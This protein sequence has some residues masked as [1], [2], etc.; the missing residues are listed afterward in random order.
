VIE[1]RH[2][3]KIFGTEATTVRA[4]DD[5]SFVLPQG[6][7]WSIMGPSGAGKSTVLHLAAGLTPPSEGQ[8]LV[9]GRDV[10]GLSDTEAAILRRR[11]VG[12]LLQTANLMPFLTVA[13][14]VG[15]P[16]LIDGVSQEEIDTR[17][18]EALGHINMSHRAAHEPNHLSGGEQQRVALA[19]ALVIRPAI[20]LADEPTGNLDRASGR[21]VMD[22]IRE[23]NQKL[24][25]TVLLV[26]HDPVFAAYAGRVLRLEDGRLTEDTDLTHPNAPAST[27]ASR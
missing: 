17:V 14:N 13:R 22:L 4:I 2:V 20:L 25:V 10:A 11:R 19:R 9:E 16:L 8:V 12:Y 23:I 18:T 5:L 6:A 27:M 15:L 3:T 24:G 26:T 1:F 21:A 7:F